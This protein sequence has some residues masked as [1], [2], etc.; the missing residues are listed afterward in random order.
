MTESYDAVVVGSG[1]NGLT[2]AAVLARAGLSV[3]VMEAQD[4]VGGGTRSLELTLPGFLHDHCSAVHPLGVASPAFRHLDLERH[5]LA[6]LHPDV[7]AAHPLDDGRAALM[8]RSIE[9]TADSMGADRDAWKSLIGPVV[10]DW[11]TWSD[12]WLSPMIRLPRR[13]FTLLRSAPHAVLPAVT[14]ARR[15]FEADAAKAAFAGFSAHSI[16]SLEQPM[17]GAA[18]LLFNAALHA[19]GMPVAKGG[20]QAIADSLASVIRENGGE[21]RTGTAIKDLGDLPPARVTLFDVNPGQALAI[22]GGQIGPRVRRAFS[23]FKHGWGSF[24]V[25][26]ALDGPVPW[27]NEGCRRAG[28]VHVGGTIDEIA[29]AEGQVSN[30]GHP[31]RP[32][33]IASQPTVC[34]P[35]RAPAGKHILWAYCHV[36]A[37]STVDMTEKI[38]DQLERFAPG[39]RDRVIHRTAT[40]PADFERTNRNM[41]GGDIAGGRSDGLRLIF[42]PRVGLN[43]WRMGSNLYLCSQSTPP[44]AGVHG[45]CGWWAAKAALKD[46]GRDGPQKR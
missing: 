10:K 27:T 21:I 31:D 40:D 34:D 6:W 38:T 24:K 35:G 4:E 26:F 42:R 3:V 20:S 11:A 23:R 46:L 15:S 14:V 12:T 25:D 2:A 44:G 5:G 17:T 18:G 16:A 13:P 39:F 36:P 32:F 41:V 8:T 28:T 30:G 33:L 29:E 9:E 1:P 19:V 43:P 37:G 45:M 22:A 7:A